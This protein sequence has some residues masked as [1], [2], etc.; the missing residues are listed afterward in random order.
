MHTSVPPRGSPPLP[1]T[2]GNATR[3]VRDESRLLAGYRDCSQVPSSDQENENATRGGE[4]HQEPPD[5]SVCCSRSASWRDWVGGGFC[6]LAVVLLTLHIILGT[7]DGSGDDGTD[8]II[9][10][11]FFVNIALA[12]CV[13][14]VPFMYM[15]TLFTRCKTW[16]RGRG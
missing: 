4:R 12:I 13:F 16:L 6:C 2:Y 1:V 9:G 11:L 3:Q 8:G 15:F 7:I 14:C 10:L 5:T